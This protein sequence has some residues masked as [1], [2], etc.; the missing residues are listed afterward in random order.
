MRTY[1]GGNPDLA[2]QESKGDTAGFV[3]DVPFVD[4]LSVNADWWRIRR[5][6][7]LGQRS[8]TQ[9]NE[10]DIALLTAYTQ[11][12]RAA[13]VAIGK[14]DLGSGTAGYKGDPDVQRYALTPE[15]LAAFAAYN[16]RQATNNSRRAPVGEFI[17]V[18]DDYLNLSGRDIQG[19]EVG[20]QWRGPKTRLGQLSFNSEATHYVLRRSKA[21]EVSLHEH[22]ARFASDADA[23]C[24]VARD[25]V[26][27]Q[28]ERAADHMA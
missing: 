3:L 26:A 19:Y 27:L 28:G 17:S 2:P 10:S 15:D 4:G 18:I 6:D 23:V 25:H 13:G 8:V 1:F 21:D 7:L 5:S 9:I 16:A 12:Q 24:R 20:V 22:V 14:I 11:Q